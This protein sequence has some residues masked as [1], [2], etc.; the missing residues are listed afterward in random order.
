MRLE[1][2]NTDLNFHHSPKLNILPPYLPQ[3][4][5]QSSQIICS[6]LTVCLK[7]LAVKHTYSNRLVK[8]APLSQ[9]TKASKLHTLWYP[10]T[11]L[12][13]SAADAHANLSFSPYVGTGMQNA[14]WPSPVLWMLPILNWEDAFDSANSTSILME[15][16]REHTKPYLTLK[17][18]GLYLNFS[19]MV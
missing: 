1:T 11:Y 2:T 7:E 18:Q 5:K 6:L 15:A 10:V 9:P 13:S 14:S 4:M 8:D 3:V 12:R 16:I 19:I 17:Q